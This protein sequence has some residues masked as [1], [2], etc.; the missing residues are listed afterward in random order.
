MS[1]LMYAANINMIK[2]YLQDVKPLTIA[3]GNY[4]II[5]LPAL[6]V[7]YASGFFSSAVLEHT[8]FWPSFG[9]ISL[10]AILHGFIQGVF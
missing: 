10:L 1:S 2:K 7:L 9:Y 6:I 5:A 4:V 3:S 8:N